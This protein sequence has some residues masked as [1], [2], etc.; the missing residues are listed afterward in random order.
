[1]VIVMD[2]TKVTLTGTMMVTATEKEKE[3]RTATM[4][5]S[6][7]VTETLMGLMTERVREITTVIEMVKV[8]VIKKWMEK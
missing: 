4:R 8:M 6:A 2:L 1:M 7:I 3:I 5:D